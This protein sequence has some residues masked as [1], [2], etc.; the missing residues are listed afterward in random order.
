MTAQE[1]KKTASEI[2]SANVL[3]QSLINGEIHKEDLPDDIREK[4]IKELL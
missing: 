3:L 2:Q 1:R 4:L